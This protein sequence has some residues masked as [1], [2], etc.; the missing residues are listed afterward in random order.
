MNMSNE[1]VARTGGF[2]LA[3]SATFVVLRAIGVEPYLLRLIISVVVGIA[4][5]YFLSKQVRS[6]RKKKNGDKD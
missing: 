2:M 4:V 6:Q 1:E 5:G 3:T